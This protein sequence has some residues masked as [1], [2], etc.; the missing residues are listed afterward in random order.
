[1]TSAN[2]TNDRIVED[3]VATAAGDE[4]RPLID[5]DVD[6]HR[7]QGHWLLASLGKTVLRPG[8]L[9]MTKALLDH[10]ALA[11]GETIVEFGPGVG[12]TA[13]Y[14]LAT[15]PAKYYG[16]DPNAEGVGRLADVLEAHPGVD[17]TVV[18]ADARHTGLPD[19]CADVVVGE[20]MLTMMPDDA[21]LETM[22][23][24]ARLLAPGGRY[25]V[26]EL[27]L[28]PDDIDPSVAGE[29]CRDLSRT[30]KVGAR[31]LTMRQWKRLMEQ[32]G[33]DVM[34]EHVNAMALL[35]PARMLEDEGAAGVA[36]IARNLAVNAEARRRVTAMRSV[37]R[38]HA[39]HL[40]AVGLVGVRR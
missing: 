33:F 10:A 31:P 6:D 32:A 14:L 17:A 22:K 1:M 40:C 23:E 2:T 26:H 15:S 9:A 24:A 30:I 34:F 3:A 18:R 25:A 36:R 7:K 12:K 28:K 39:D 21:K 5:S 27:G 29:L 20:A 35:E 19:A 11:A 37:F 38:Q 16:I 8:G 4:R 13:Q